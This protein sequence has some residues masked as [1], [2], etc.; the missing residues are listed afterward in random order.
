MSGEPPPSEC[1]FP[2]TPERVDIAL[3]VVL[4]GGKF[5]VA[6]RAAGLHLAGYWEFPGGKIEPGETPPG[7]ACRELC[8]ETGLRAGDA[9]PLTIV[10]H[11]YREAPLRIHVFLV[12]EPDGELTI[13]GEREHRW[14]SFEEL[15]AIE[16]PAANREIVRA[17]RWRIG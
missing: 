17:L 8:E 9:E 12:R 14:L 10:V 5:L 1:G 7:A 6:R 3:A 15:A 13:D 16:M 11:D 4:R 2:E